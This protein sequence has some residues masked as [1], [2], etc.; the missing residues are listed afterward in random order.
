MLRLLPCTMR[1]KARLARLLLGRLLESQD[2]EL[3]DR[4]GSVITVPSLREPVAFHLLVDGLYEPETLAFL[5]DRV[6]PGSVF[7]DIGANVGVFTIPVARK[8][9]G[10]GCVVSLEA[11]P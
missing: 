3:H 4:D 7:V 2:V 1:G 9:R 6:A 11:S 10:T 5:L 8:L